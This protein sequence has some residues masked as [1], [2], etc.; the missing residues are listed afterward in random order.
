M[1]GRGHVGAALVDADPAAAVTRQSPR[2]RRRV[3]AEQCTV[4]AALHP[5]RRAA[6]SRPRQVRASSRF[7]LHQEIVAA[8]ARRRHHAYLD[9]I[10]QRRVDELVAL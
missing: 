3:T 10:G 4:A 5:V 9:E 2:V 7:D 8:P 6:P 1:L